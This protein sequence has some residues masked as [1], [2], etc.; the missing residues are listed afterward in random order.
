MARRQEIRARWRWSRSL[1]A[2]LNGVSSGN[3]DVAPFAR[4]SDRHGSR[5]AA[6]TLAPASSPAPIIVRDTPAL[7]DALQKAGP[8]TRILLAPGTYAGGIYHAGLR[9]APGRPSSSA[10]SI[11]PAA[12]D[13]RRRHGSASERPVH[14]ELRDLVLRG[15][16]DNGLN[17]DDG[18][19]YDTPARHVRLINLRVSDLSTPTGN[20][21]GIKLSGLDDFRIE[22]CQI[23]RWSNGGQGID[24]VGCHRGVIE[25]CTLRESSSEGVQAKG[26]TSD[27][28]I[29]R[30]RFEQVGGRGAN[31]GGST[32]LQFF[33]P[34]L[35]PESERT[36]G[37]PRFAEGRNLRVEGCTFV[38]GDAPVAFVGVD[39][40]TVRFNTI[41]RPRHWAVRILQETT[42]PGFVP[43]RKGVFSDNLVVF[44]S[45]QWREGGVNIGPNT[46]PQ[47]FTFA[48][49][50]WFCEDD[51]ARSRPTLPTP[52]TNGVYGV[53][54]RLRDPEKGD[55]APA[56]G[57]PAA[58]FGAHALPQPR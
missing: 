14:V 3:N 53:N 17:I 2:P 46:A 54:P 21:D 30:C 44:R 6:A 13:R 23:A 51:P 42:A 26:G 20:H 25:N 35:P 50:F 10:R 19:T 12:R 27:V 9:G 33:R 39:G 31:L 18:G 34:P 43:S 11:P 40:A 45:D 37:T 58:R 1:A 52:E 5:A 56:P 8:G 32:G 36:A 49:N 57:S 22:N 41:Y 16:R 47:T 28:T 48:R 24:M 7:R 4:W 29:R 15:A 55:L 38:G